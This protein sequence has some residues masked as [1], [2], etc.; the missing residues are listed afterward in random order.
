MLSLRCSIPIDSFTICQNSIRTKNRFQE[1]SDFLPL[2]NLCFTLYKLLGG[3][4]VV[5]ECMVSLLCVGNRVQDGGE[6]CRS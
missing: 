2:H 5:S 6:N 1:N 3:K 4:L